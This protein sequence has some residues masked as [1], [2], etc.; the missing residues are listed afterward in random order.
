MRDLT[1]PALLDALTLAGLAGRRR[2]FADRRRRAGCAGKI[3]CHPGHRGGRGL[4][5]RPA[6][7]PGSP[8][9][10]DRHHFRGSRGT[11]DTV[12]ARRHIHIGRSVRWNAGDSGGPRR[13]HDQCRDHPRR[14]AGR[15]RARGARARADLARRAGPVLGMLAASSRR[16]SGSRGAQD[17][18]HATLC[19]AIV[20]WR[21]SAARIS[22][23]RPKNF[24]RAGRAS[25]QQ[26]CGSA[27]KFG[28]LA[29]G[30]ADIYP[31]LAPT[32][33][34]DIAAGDAILTGAGGRVVTP[35]GEPVLYGR[36]DGGF[37]IPAFIAWGDA[38]ARI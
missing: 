17:D 8:A 21:W 12:Q 33:E 2:N 36:H 5:G 23:R 18:L 30:D 26:G 7:G 27:L 16:R 29:Q 1:A 9:S 11:G 25:R 24:S 22:I 38:A 20:R 14:T 37:R 32:S 10:R 28:L 13:I 15:G 34:W 3:R 4:R 6:D 35:D 31:R 19:A